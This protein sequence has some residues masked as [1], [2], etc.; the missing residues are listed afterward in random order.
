M[1]FLNRRAAAGA[2]VLALALA[3]C[4]AGDPVSPAGSAQGQSQP[5]LAGVTNATRPSGTVDIRTN[6]Q[7]NPALADALGRQANN[8]RGRHWSPGFGVWRWVDYWRNRPTA[9]L[10]DR[11]DTRVPVPNTT[12][13]GP[14]TD[15]Y[16]SAFAGGYWELYAAGGAI[17]GLKPATAYSLAFVHYR[18]VRAGEVDH[19]DRILRGNAQVRDTLKVLSGTTTLAIGAWTSASPAGCP[20]YPGTTAN[21]LVVA[22]FVSTAGGESPGFDQCI[23][24]GNGLGEDATPQASSLVGRNDNQAYDLPNYNYIVVYETA[25]GLDSTALRMQIAQDL[26]PNGTP[27]ANA[28]APFPAPAVNTNNVLTGGQGHATVDQN[29]AFPISFS[30]Q[31]ALPAAFGEPDS[32]IVRMQ[33]VQRLETGT[34]KA[35]Y[36]N[37]TTNEAKPAIGRYIRRSITVSAADTALRDTTVFE[38]VAGT[39]TFKGGPQEIIFV[40]RPYGEIGNPTVADSLSTLLITIEQNEN[41]A[42]PSNSQPFWV[43]GI[44]KNA[45]TA[46]PTTLNF[47]DAN[48]NQGTAAPQIFTAQG[49]FSGGVIG[50]TTIIG[51]G[52]DTEVV[53]EGTTVRLNFSGL[54]R[55]PEGYEYV[56]YMCKDTC[57]PLLPASNFLSMGTLLGPGNEDLTQADNP[58]YTSANVVGQRISSAFLTYDFAGSGTT[59]CEFDRF[60]LALQPKGAVEIPTTYVID[61][62]LSATIT[63]ADACR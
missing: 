33:N 55:P 61:A 19:V 30:A 20:T 39:S 31:L 36:V 6:I 2:A 47:G 63:R 27:V 11:R 43:N 41:A 3:A 35:W 38:D 42:A 15:L 56:A 29:P 57:S 46:L 37:R 40:T 50:D 22:Q 62:P 58:S 60:R 21:P 12:A 32:I 45:G 51:Q 10:G 17:T 13:V 52:E 4:D 24:P 7:L 26:A 49:T 59:V 34:Y 16:P 1:S 53:F 5:L 25:A 9:N 8:P 18:L 28:F 14:I 44:I 54:T 48:F 23:V